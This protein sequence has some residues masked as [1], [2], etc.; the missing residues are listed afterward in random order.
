MGAG[1]YYPEEGPP[2]EVFVDGFSISRTPITN[3][4]FARFVAETGYKTTAEIPPKLIQ[5]NALNMGG[6]APGSLVFDEPET[7]PNANDPHLWWKYCNG[8][9]WR[10]PTG[11]GS[12]LNGLED[13]PVVHVSH[14]DAQAYAAWVG[15]RL[16][17]EAEWERA[18]RGGV[19]GSIYAWGDKFMPD[20]KRMAKTWEGEF[21]W[22]NTAPQG[23]MRTAPVG[24]YP[25]NGFGLYDMIGNVWEW[26]SD[27]FVE[28]S[29]GVACCAPGKDAGEVGCSR[30]AQIALKGGS[31]LCD[32]SYCRRYRPAARISLTPDT[33]TCHVSFRCVW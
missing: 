7:I 8:A 32:A 11:K 20:G 5:S 24:S 14:F 22:H 6:I 31:F 19:D 25:A 21:P 28:P 9:Q 23:L 17:S 16:P 18:A 10:R 27:I 1:D 15:G 2:R 29:L 33:S 3:R 13:H 12:A 4:Q 30:G 26:T